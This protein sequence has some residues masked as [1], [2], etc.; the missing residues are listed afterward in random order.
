MAPTIA[1]RIATAFQLNFLSGL[2][3]TDVCELLTVDRVTLTASVHHDRNNTGN[4]NHPD[5]CKDD[6]RFSPD[7]HKGDSRDC[8][9]EFGNP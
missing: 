9:D 1:A 3:I 2:F 5:R 7:D 8:V 6:L 4:A